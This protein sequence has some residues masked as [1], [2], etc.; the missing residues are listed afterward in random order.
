M[1]SL[2]LFDVPEILSGTKAFLFY[3]HV[4][5]QLNGWFY[6]PLVIGISL[7]EASAAE[8]SLHFCA[9]V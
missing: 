5:T 4:N 7:C 9:D 1:D 8:C 2:C 3:H 6:F